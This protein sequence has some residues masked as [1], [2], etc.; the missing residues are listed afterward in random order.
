MSKYA[1][2]ASPKRVNTVKCFTITPQRLRCD[3]NTLHWIKGWPG[4]DPLPET[5]VTICQLDPGEQTS[6]KY[7]SKYEMSSAKRRVLFS[8]LKV[9]MFYGAEQWSS[10][11]LIWLRWIS[12]M[13]K[14]WCFT[15]RQY[16]RK[17][18]HWLSA[19]FFMMVREILDSVNIKMSYDINL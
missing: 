9:L 2:K 13:Y 3:A 17:R 7:K 11:C 1:F 15:W 14:R 6:L 16:P 19:C 5:M 18:G 8:D 4:A 12:M 10:H